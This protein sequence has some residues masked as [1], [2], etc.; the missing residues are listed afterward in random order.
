[1]VAIMREPA[2]LTVFSNNY[3]QL[4]LRGIYTLDQEGYDAIS[5]H[6]VTETYLIHFCFMFRNE[7]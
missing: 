6:G 1:M 5:I 4:S 2:Y 3:L 7:L